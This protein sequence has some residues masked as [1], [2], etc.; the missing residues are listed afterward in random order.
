MPSNVLT[1]IRRNFHLQFLCFQG[2]LALMIQNLT[3]RCLS[4][5]CKAV[6]CKAVFCS[7]VLREKNDLAE[8]G[9][10]TPHYQRAETRQ[11]VDLVD[12]RGNT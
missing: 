8:W 2:T 10:E 4:F 11:F 1:H 12:V 5:L 7:R 3:A 6:F 9:G